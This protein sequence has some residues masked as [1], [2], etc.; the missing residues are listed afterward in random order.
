MIEM[1]VVR[2]CMTSIVAF[3]NYFLRLSYRV[4]SIPPFL[5]A[6]EPKA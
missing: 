6:D 3:C 2:D 4:L 5:H 1:G